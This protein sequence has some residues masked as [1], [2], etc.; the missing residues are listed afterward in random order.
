MISEEFRELRR[1]QERYETKIEEC[2][3]K[4]LE[5]KKEI[6]EVPSLLEKYLDLLDPETPEEPGN[7]FYRKH[8][9]T[10]Y[11]KDIA[12]KAINY[13]YSKW[14]SGEEVS[15]FDKMIYY[16][17]KRIINEGHFREQIPAIISCLKRDGELP[18]ITDSGRTSY[19]KTG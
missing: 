11:S 3:L 14:N 16:N 1:Q 6:N 4:I 2:E 8:L 7:E 19:S 12:H 10:G 9:N 17:S 5:L 13:I 18:F 15:V